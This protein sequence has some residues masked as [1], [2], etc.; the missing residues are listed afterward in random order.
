MGACLR[1]RL[2][3]S[4][5]HDGQQSSRADIVME[6]DRRQESGAHAAVPAKRMRGK[7]WSGM[8]VGVIH[9]SFNGSPSLALSAFLDFLLTWLG[10][11][12]VREE[13]TTS[14]CSRCS[15]KPPYA[16]LLSVSPSCVLSHLYAKI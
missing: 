6:R 15:S 12:L 11:K 9:A 5:G 16:H 3:S 14:P 2:T 4:A 13:P 1:R 7:K 10:G 8:T